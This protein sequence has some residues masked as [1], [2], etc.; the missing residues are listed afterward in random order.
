MIRAREAREVLRTRAEGHGR[1]V[2]ATDFKGYRFVAVGNRMYYGKD[3]RFFTDFLLHHMKEVLGRGW[4]R[5]AVESEAPH[6]VLTWLKKMNELRDESQSANNSGVLESRG[7]GFVSAV[8]RFAYALYLIA[9][10]DVIP[11]TL[12]R[13]LRQPMEFR[14]AAL[15]TIVVAAFA[16]AGYKIR[17]GEDKKG[18]GPEG[19][20]R[21]TSTKTG[22]VFDVEA[23]RKN[24]WKAPVDVDDNAFQTELNLWIK[25][26]IYV[27]AKKK[28]VNPVY[29]LELS[30]AH[31]QDRSEV[32]KLQVLVRQALREAE[33]SIKVEGQIPAPAYVF[34]TSHA[35]LVDGE[36]NDTTFV[37]LEGFHIH[38]AVTG[39][40]VEIEQALAAR[41][42]DR[43]ISWILECLQKVQMVPHHFDGTPDDLVDDNKLPFKRLQVGERLEIT[44]PNEGSVIGTVLNVVS[45][46]EDAVVTIWNERTHKEEILRVPLSEQERE[47]ASTIGDVAFGNPNAG[48]KI[49]DEDPLAIYDFFLDTY[50]KSSREK[51]L[52]FLEKHPRFDEFKNLSTD[53]LRTRVCREWAKS[54]LADHEER[55]AKKS[56][57]PPEKD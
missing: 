17:M 48:R 26:K 8:F 13:R 5:R 25:R 32:E 10:H 28:L 16:L 1:P 4:G 23:K 55:L 19:E 29:W 54:A 39:E 24:G 11:S 46:G 50:T 6:P 14:S 49:P 52:E 37:M 15:E 3:W 56:A 20:F 18:A 38:M 27:A 44:L 22:K 34:V 12:I 41:D 7:H 45:L 31:F 9:H 51:L 47:I 36:P 33:G 57:Q 53:E 43:D 21:A 40:R 30:I 2:I 42:R 35:F